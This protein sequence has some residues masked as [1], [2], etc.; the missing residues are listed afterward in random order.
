MVPPELPAPQIGIKYARESLFLKVLNFLP[1]PGAGSM[2]W[3]FRWLVIRGRSEKRNG[4]LGP[5]HNWADL[6][7]EKFLNLE[8]TLCEWG[9]YEFCRGHFHR[10][11]NFVAFAKLRLRPQNK[12]PETVVLI[13]SQENPGIIEL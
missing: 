7:I 12:I 6:Q 5:E 8:K 4:N 3:P 11:I 13:K 2:V 9:M 1:C 10:D